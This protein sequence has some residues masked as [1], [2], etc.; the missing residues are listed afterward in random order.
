MKIDQDKLDEKVH[1][2]HGRQRTF[3]LENKPTLNSAWEIICADGEVIPCLS[4]GKAIVEL[5][6]LHKDGRIAVLRKRPKLESK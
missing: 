2:A 6:K 5:G 3:G 4:E 1:K